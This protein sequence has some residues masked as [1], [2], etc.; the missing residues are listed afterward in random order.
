MKMPNIIFIIIF[1]I[2]LLLPLSQS[3]FGFAPVQ[4]L[5]GITDSSVA[6]KFYFKNFILGVFQE[7]FESWFNSRIGFKG[8][9]VKTDNQINFSIFKEITGSSNVHIILGEDNFL[10]EKGYVDSLNKRD[11][12]EKYELENEVIKI[13]KAQDILK[14]RGITFLFVIAPSKASVLSEY[15]PK[16]YLDENKLLQNTNYDNI[17]PILDKYNINYVDAH[18]YSI[19]H[20]DR[21]LN[22]FFV[23]G[24]THWS[25]YGA[26]LFS[27]EILK[28][29]EDLT[30]RNF[31]DISC[32]PPEI[33][34]EPTGTDKD[35]S[36]LLNIWDNDVISGE[37][38]HPYYQSNVLGNEYK[39]NIIAVGDSFSWTLLNIMEAMKVYKSRDFFYY[40]NTNYEYPE[41][42]KVQIEQD[43][44]NWEEDIF[45]NDIVIL[46]AN[47]IGL[48]DI[49]FGFIDD[50]IKYN[51]L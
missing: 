39:P 9:L 49:G 25:Y 33:D 7:E 19:Q 23:R 35:L 22:L 47:E 18:K 4:K 2:L 8:Y 5:N 1:S 30:K 45:K 15:I 34:N 46:E 12:L 21:M 29:L 31:V 20:K 38:A 48:K 43:K 11:A 51:S 17:V 36:E 14:E 24:G 42:T 6:P 27:I 44:I 3:V 40:Y 28:K 13:K 50:L 41:N 37:T 16:K 26:C 32:D 10:F